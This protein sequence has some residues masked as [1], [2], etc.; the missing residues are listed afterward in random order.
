MAYRNIQSKKQKKS[1]K[2]ILTVRSRKNPRR[3]IN[4]KKEKK[5][6]QEILKVRRRK[7]PKKK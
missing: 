1:H 6:W 7:N 5:C 2:E 4:T 3:T